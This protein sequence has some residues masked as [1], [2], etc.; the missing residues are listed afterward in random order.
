MQA[1]FAIGYGGQEE[2][3]RAVQELA[4]SGH[5]MAHIQREDILSVL[6]TGRFPAPDMIVRTGGHM[7]HSGYFL[8]QSP[9]A[10]YFFSEKNWPDFD[11]D[12]LDRVIES[13]E[14]RTRKF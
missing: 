14:N 13:Y 9:Y 7:R 8:F 12:E 2:I 10:E 3:T 6:D 5:D 1:I 4:R 11:E